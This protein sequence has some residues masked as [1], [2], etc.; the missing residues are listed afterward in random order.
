MRRILAA[1]AAAAVGSLVVAP[2]AFGHQVANNC[3]A[4]NSLN[5]FDSTGTPL[6]AQAPYKG[7]KQ[8][9][10]PVGPG[11][12]VDDRD[13]VGWGVFMSLP[14]R[15]VEQAK[16]GGVG[17]VAYEHDHS[18]GLWLYEESGKANGLQTGGDADATFGN[19]PRDVKDAFYSNVGSSLDACLS[20]QAS[21]RDYV[22][23]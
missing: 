19:L 23:F 2:A 4:N 21:Q 5:P 15:I 6:D 12:H 9:F 1:L 11:Y 7:R 22:I 18:G 13:Y 8:Y 3:G 10:V 14:S 16:A 17:W 20:G